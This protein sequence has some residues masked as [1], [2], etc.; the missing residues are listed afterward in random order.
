MREG[1]KNNQRHLSLRAKGIAR[2]KFSTPLTR[3][4]LRRRKRRRSAVIRK[5]DCKQ[6]NIGRGPPG[7]LPNKEVAGEVSHE[8]RQSLPIRYILRSAL[9]S[10]ISSCDFNNRRSSRSEKLT[11]ESL[12]FSPILNGARHGLTDAHSRLKRKRK[13]RIVILNTRY[14]PTIYIYITEQIVYLFRKRSNRSVVAFADIG[15]RRVVASVVARALKKKFREKCRFREDN[16][17]N[18]SVPNVIS[19]LLLFPFRKTPRRTF[20]IENTHAAF[21]ITPGGLPRAYSASHSHAAESRGGR[22]AP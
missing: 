10:K 8:R 9:P 14:T 22:D 12:K 11:G 6:C 16:N 1:A 19:F 15:T 21:A 18:L 4:N 5:R 2:N 13:K 20:A 3:A 17:A 7:K